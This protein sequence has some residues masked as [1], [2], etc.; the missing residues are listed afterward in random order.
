[1]E[2]KII[3][4]PALTFAGVSGRVPLQF[5]GINNEIVKLA[6]VLLWS[7]VRRCIVYRILS[8]M[9]LLI[10]RMIRIQIFLRKTVH[11]RI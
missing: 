9:K 7:N 5:E 2:Y 11:L 3:E 1:M 10:C 4:K 6:Q 8:R